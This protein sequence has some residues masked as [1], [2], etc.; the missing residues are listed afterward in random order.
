MHEAMHTDN[1]SYIGTEWNGT[2]NQE[3]LLPPT[4]VTYIKTYIHTD[5]RTD[6]LTD[7][8]TGWLRKMYEEMQAD[9]RR[10]THRNI[11]TDR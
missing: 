2:G 7:V 1:R 10:Y 9:S 3:D 5:R 8:Q 4:L 11:H 6:R